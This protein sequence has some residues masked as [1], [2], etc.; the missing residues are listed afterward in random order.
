MASSKTNLQSIIQ[1]QNTVPFFP[2]KVEN[3][4][5]NNDK[6]FVRN[7]VP[8]LKECHPKFPNFS[9]SISVQYDPEGVRG[10]YCV[11]SRDIEVGELLAVETPFVWLLDKESSRVHCWHCFR[12]LL[13]PVP[14]VQ[15]AGT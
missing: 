13:A 12:P 7:L 11:A 15:C 4:V 14:C 1:E 3:G 5:T 8:E 2:D 10:R 6:K 9:S